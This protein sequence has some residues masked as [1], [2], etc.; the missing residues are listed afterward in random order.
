MGGKGH[1]PKRRYFTGIGS[2]SMKMVANR[3]RHVLIITSNGDEL[4]RNV[5][6]DDFE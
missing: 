1:P 3:H 5:I 4:L 6:T 2:S